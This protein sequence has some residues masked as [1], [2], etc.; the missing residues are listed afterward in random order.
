MINK[1]TL[2]KL[3]KTC[4]LCVRIEIKRFL[5]PKSRNRKIGIFV[6]I[7]TRTPTSLQSD[8]LFQE[9]IPN[10]VDLR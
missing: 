7:T 4:V 3:G 8:Q 2:R 5:N 1:I 6:I 10:L 9:K